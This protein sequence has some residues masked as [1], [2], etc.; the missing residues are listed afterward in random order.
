MEHKILWVAVLKYLRV[1]VRGRF[2]TPG[3]A[4]E[5]NGEANPRQGTDTTLD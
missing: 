4:I 2:F 3:G 5:G 1:V